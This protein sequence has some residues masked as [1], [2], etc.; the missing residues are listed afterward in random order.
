MGESPNI[1]LVSIDLQPLSETANLLINKIS[2][3]IGWTITRETPKKKAIE[4]Y[5][6]DIQNDPTLD[7]LI[8]AAMVT[9]AKKIIHEYCNQHDVVRLA[10]NNLGGAT[11]D[12]INS[13]DDSWLAFV[14]DRI[15][16]VNS[17]ELK[18][19]WG[20][21]LAQEC[22]QP[23]SIS[24]QLLSIVEIMDTY[25]AKAFTLLKSHSVY[26]HD[27]NPNYIPI[28]FYLDNQQYFDSIGLSYSVLTNLA[29]IGLLSLDT[30]RGFSSRP[31]KENALLQ[32]GSHFFVID[33]PGFPT[34]QTGNVMLTHAGEQLCQ[35]IDAEE[36]PQFIE[37]CLPNI[38]IKFHQVYSH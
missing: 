25:L 6:E 30:F 21:I 10:I 17:S 20:H 3:A 33:E 38:G 1:S 18:I 11:A 16:L 2:N 35:V 37:H 26:I 13:V 9:N 28:F 23:N 19:M 14:M 15:R 8:K 32:Y 12:S 7:P 5:I 22:T 34:F 29:A 31:T 27:N 36:C 24:K 4:K